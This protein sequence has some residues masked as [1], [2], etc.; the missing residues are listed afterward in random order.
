VFSLYIDEFG[1]YEVQEFHRTLI[2]GG[3]DLLFRRVDSK[4]IVKE[5]RTVLR[6]VE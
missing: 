1:E 3:L 2:D 6:R 4:A 5:I